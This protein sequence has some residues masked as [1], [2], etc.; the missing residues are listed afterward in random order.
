[1]PIDF[2]FKNYLEDVGSKTVALAR[3]NS[4]W[5]LLVGGALVVWGRAGVKPTSSSGARGDTAGILASVLQV[6]EG[7]MQIGGRLAGRQRIVADVT[8]DETK[9]SAHFAVEE[10]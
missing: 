5:P 8:Q 2:V 7:G 4:W 3:I 10:N 1:M 9:N 6:V